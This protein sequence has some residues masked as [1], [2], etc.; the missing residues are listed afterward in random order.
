MTFRIPI[1]ATFLNDNQMR[2]SGR[3]PYDTLIRGDGKVILTKWFNSRPVYFAFSCSEI[4][5]LGSCTRCSKTTNKY[6]SV[7]RLAIVADYNNKMGGIDLLDRATG[8]YAMHGC[9]K[10]WT[11]RTIY[12]FF[13][14]AVAVCWLKY[15]EKASAEGL[16]RKYILDYLDFKLSIAKFWF[17]PRSQKK[18]LNN[19][20]LIKNPHP[21]NKEKFSLFQIGKS[22]FY[23]T[24]TPTSIH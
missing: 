13:D 20:N 5:P 8:K 23:I 3:G 1:N 11:G 4:E 17:L 24:Y 12:N 10:N 19:A 15:R 22:E 7:K 21:K 18:N 9:T 2:T 14:F 6:I 16:R